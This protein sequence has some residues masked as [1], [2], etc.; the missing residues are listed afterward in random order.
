MQTRVLLIDADDTLWQNNIYFE[1]VIG[2]T[3]R[4]LES[5]GADA[6]NFRS[7]LDDTERRRIPLNGYGTVNFT[8]SLVET[9][10]A[11]MPPGCDPMA[12]AQ[13]E[14]WSLGILAHP[15]EV[16]E[17]VPETLEYLARSQILFLVT[18]GEPLE[19]ARKIRNS[20]LMKHF[21]DVVIL[22][23]KDIRIYRDLV[24]NHGWAPAATWMIGNSPRSDINPALA[25]GLNAIYI[26]HVHTWTLEHE[27][28][29]EHP[30]LTTLT[31]FADLRTHFPERRT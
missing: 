30:R 16:F 7:T 25:A 20:N 15:I 2:K 26:P 8:H 24:E 6:G 4:L 17:G 23:E 31:R 5:L 18:K 10:K 21:Q 28:P 1:R 9:F 19:Q 11:F 29:V 12:A 3:R 22:P 27:P 14:Q 13:V